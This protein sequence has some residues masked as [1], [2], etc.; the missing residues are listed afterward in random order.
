MGFGILCIG[1]GEEKEMCLA[2][3]VKKY[4]IQI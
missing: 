2:V 4:Q 3:N 1:Y